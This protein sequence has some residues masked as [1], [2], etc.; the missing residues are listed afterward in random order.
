[1]LLGLH[2]FA[3]SN[4]I[5]SDSNSPSLDPG[6]SFDIQSYPDEIVNNLSIDNDQNEDFLAD[7]PTS[8]DPDTSDLS[9][10]SNDDFNFWQKR[11][12]VCRPR[13]Q[14]NQYQS[15]DPMS[16][17]VP[18]GPMSEYNLAEPSRKD[19]PFRTQQTPFTCAGP[20]AYLDADPEHK[21]YVGNCE[22]GKYSS[23]QT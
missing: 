3:L 11:N 7:C 6:S 19:C 2:R 4:P 12:S 18:H 13:A 17:R 16:N 8:S 10:N 5:S 14:N 20:E 21:N 1:M 23:F 15:G 22:P 9:D